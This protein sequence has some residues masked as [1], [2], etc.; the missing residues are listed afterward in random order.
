MVLK[1]QF[2]ERPTLVPV[3]DVVLEGLS[4]RGEKRPPLLIVPPRPDEG[5][6]MDHVVA[7][8]LAWAAASSG[9]PTLRFNYRGVGGSQGKP[10]GFQG[11]VVDAEAALTVLAENVSGGDGADVPIAVASIGGSAG[12]AMALAKRHP[13]VERLALIAPRDVEPKEWVRLSRPLLVVVAE[14]DTALSR[15][16]LAAAVAE[17]AGQLEVVQKADR[18]FTR[19]LAQVGKA[20]AD[21]LRSARNH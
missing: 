3:S 21:F 13:G 6:S 9:H 1:G 7:A 11:H 10:T 12:V 16:A 5:G 8:E 20:V 17:A 15:A 19:G 4:H 18:A 2:L 14:R